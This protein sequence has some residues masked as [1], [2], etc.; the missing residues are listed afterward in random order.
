MNK[1]KYI[2]NIYSDNIV[3]RKAQKSDEKALAELAYQAYYDRFFNREVTDIYGASLRVYPKLIPN[4]EKDTGQC[5]STF[6][7]YWKK[8]IQNLDNPDQRFLCFVAEVY[9]PQGK[10]IVGFRKGY[11]LPLEDEEYR[12]Y[13]NENKKRALIRKRNDYYGINTY[14][15]TR[16]ISLPPQN[17]I[18]GSSSLYISPDFKRSGLGRRL[19]KRYAQEVIKLGFTGMMTSCY[20]KNDSQKFLKSMGGDFFI[21][22]NIPVS[23]RK[24][25]KTLDICNIE[26]LMCLWDEKTLQKLAARENNLSQDMMF[27]AYKS[28]NIKL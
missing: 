26:G 17:K 5:L 3:I 9:T 7:E 15:D 23:Y 27:N 19:I 2:M 18:A 22:C 16:E 24:E 6:Q 4:E 1:E 13:V 14:D 28:A 8:A 12:R 20:V 21:K 10:K 25:D 11:A